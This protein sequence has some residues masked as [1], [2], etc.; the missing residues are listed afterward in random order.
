MHKHVAIGAAA[1]VALSTAWAVSAHF[2]SASG[3]VNSEGQLVV[4]FKE[5]GLGSTPV[6][7]DYELSTVASADYQCFN[8]GSNSP[9]GQ[10]FQVQDQPLTV[11]GSF[12]SGKNGAINGTLYAGPPNPAPAEAALKCVSTG[13][14]LCM[15]S[16]SYSDSTLTDTTFGVS[17]GVPPNP[18]ERSFP[19]PTK[20][21]PLPSSCITSL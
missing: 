2:N 18:A 12:Q 20:R 9:Q 14:K 13:K 10:P 21:N 15:L 3:A 11:G 16:V 19:V 7:V 17:I 5:V 8:N 1:L 4:T 6:L